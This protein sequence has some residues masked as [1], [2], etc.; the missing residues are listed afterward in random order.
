MLAFACT[1]ALA[2]TT[3]VFAATLTPGAVMRVPD[4]PL[5]GTS[6]CAPIVA[7]QEALGSK[8]YPDSEVEPYIT[9]DPTRPGHLIGVV[10]Q[11]R[12]NDGGANGATTV[13]STNGG[14]T[15]TLATKQP[16]LTICEGATPGSPGGLNRSSDPW[17]SVG[18]DGT[19]YQGS[20]TFNANGP[21]FG[22]TSGVEVSTSTDGGMTWGPARDVILDQSLTV[23]NDKDSVTAD[24]NIAGTAY[25]VWDR[26]VSP[27]VNANPTAFL[28]T[29][30]FEGPAMFSKTTDGGAT[31]STPQILF[32]PGQN[33]QTLGNQIVVEPDGTLVDGTLVFLNKGG[34]G[35]NRRSLLEV[36]VMR[37]TDGGATWSA[38]TVVSPLQDAPV[39]IA[40]TLVRTGDTLPE[41]AVDSTTGTLYATWQDG[42]FSPNGVAH[43]AFSQSTDGGLTWSAPIQIDQAPA[44][45]PAWTP[46]AHVASDGTIGVTYYDLEPATAASPGLT[47]EFIVNCD[48]ASSDCTQASSW[49]SGEETMLNT[50]GAF[51]MTTAPFAVGLFTGDY[52]GLTS[53]GTTFDALFV[54]SKPIATTGDTDQFFNTA[55]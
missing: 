20:L 46:V 16:P 9:A 24:P 51:D 42:R 54:M 7:Q 36:V 26:L 37:S 43:V 6:V 38:P 40:G 32:D 14:A 55:S 31:W 41:F 5:A 4:N 34:K 8:L 22:G 17:V 15:W 49:A 35:H 19:A 30:A 28:H 25:V 48:P 45:V 13:V 39:T 18:P 44:S 29:P 52:E 3:T 2:G 27:S 21:G 1:A 12:W 33:N 53:I 11:D 10:Q 23:L 47:D 50:S